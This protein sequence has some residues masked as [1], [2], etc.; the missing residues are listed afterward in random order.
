MSTLTERKQFSG[1]DLTV[2][3]HHGLD[4]LPLVPE[5]CHEQFELF[6]RAP[7]RPGSTSNSADLVSGE[8]RWSLSQSTSRTGLISE[9]L[10]GI[11]P[12]DG[13][14]GA[15]IDA[16]LD[17]HKLGGWPH[18]RFLPTSSD[19]DSNQVID[20]NITLSRNADAGLPWATGIYKRP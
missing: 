6:L 14:S 15:E 1:I 20:D 3:Q 11:T 7:M 12:K 19:G 16:F 5:D 2:D 13:F 9:F 10:L 18:V 8:T 4:L 17:K